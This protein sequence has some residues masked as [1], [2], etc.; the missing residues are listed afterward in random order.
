MKY[1]LIAFDLDGTA[2]HSDRQM[3][4]RLRNACR[5]AEE[6]GVLTVVCSGRIYRSTL[7]YSQFLGVTSAMAKAG[8]CSIRARWKNR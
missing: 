7:R 6:K 4:E 5:R 2:L 1:R 3:S 8:K